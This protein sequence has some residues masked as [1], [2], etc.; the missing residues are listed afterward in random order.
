MLT[1]DQIERRRCGIGSS[2]IPAIVGV[3]PHAGPIDVYLDKIGLAEERSTEATGL[4]DRAEAFVAEL[5]REQ[6]GACLYAGPGTKAHPAHP[7]ALATP[8][9]LRA[10]ALIEIKLVGARM[11]HLWEDGVPAHV[12]AQVQWQLEVCDVERADVAALLGGTEFR[13]YPVERDRARA[14]DLLEAGRRFWHE[15]IIA[16]VPPPHTGADARRLAQLAHPRNSGEM[17]PRTFE[18]EHLREA[19]LAL[20]CQEQAL[21]DQR[22]RLEAEAMAMIG[23]ADGIDGCFTWRRARG[24]AWKAAARKRFVE[25]ARANFD[26]VAEIIGDDPAEWEKLGR[27]VGAIPDDNEGRRFLVRRTKEERDGERTGR[28]SALPCAQGRGS[29]EDLQGALPPLGRA[30]PDEW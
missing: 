19:I 23:D 2:D 25:L 21:A 12:L 17:R 1:P 28:A 10:G 5:Y 29:E 18:A 14:A 11:V 26:R 8:D 27:A 7:W 3:S 6:T 22:K 30:I 9:R 4:G 13:V 15:H 16:R 20:R 24:D